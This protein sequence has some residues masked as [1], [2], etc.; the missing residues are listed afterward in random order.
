MPKKYPPLKD[1]I[2]SAYIESPWEFQDTPCWLWIRYK[3]QA[4]Y[5]QMSV[6]NRPALAHRL[7]YELWKGPIPEGLEIDHLCRVRACCNPAHLE[8]V[9]RSVNTLRGDSPRISRARHQAVTHCP[10][11]H[12]YN[13]EN[14]RLYQG[15]RF[16]RACHA[17]KTLARYHANKKEEAR[18]AQFPAGFF[19]VLPSI[20][21]SP[22]FI[23]V[24]I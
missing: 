3:S 5:G 21:T 10:K 7:A 18:R 11:G 1:R 8:A 2:Q 9:T 22:D 4:G 16:C 17:Q 15:R 19:E 6:N 14:T 12:P 23:L 20:T 13:E 24:H